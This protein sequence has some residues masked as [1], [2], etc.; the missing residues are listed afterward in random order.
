MLWAAS[1]WCSLCLTWIWQSLRIHI[2]NTVG[3]CVFD[4]LH[5]KHSP[6]VFRLWLSPSSTHRDTSS[7]PHLSRTSTIETLVLYSIPC[8]L[9]PSLSF[10]T[11]PFHHTFLFCNRCFVFAQLVDAGTYS[12]MAT[13]HGDS[14]SHLFLDAGLAV[15]CLWLLCLH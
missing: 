5:D 13:R 15:L 11:T 2:R 7:T 14:S 1:N 10:L 6:S 12:V 9:H 4:K 3:S 8:K